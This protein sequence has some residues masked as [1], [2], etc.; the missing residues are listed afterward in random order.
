MSNHT[1]AGLL[2]LQSVG[3]LVSNL[4]Q[5]KSVSESVSQSISQYRQGVSRSV[6]QFFIHSQS[7]IQIDK[8]KI[9]I[10]RK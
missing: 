3:Q 8:I 1:Y 4:A 5:R 7:F 6:S 9:K 2:A 10:D